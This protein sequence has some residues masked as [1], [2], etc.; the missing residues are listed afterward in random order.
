MCCTI[1]RQGIRRLWQVEETAEITDLCI[2]YMDDRPVILYVNY[3]RSALGLVSMDG[4]SLSVSVDSPGMKEPYHTASSRDGRRLVVAGWEDVDKGP[5]TWEVYSVLNDHI[6]KVKTFP[7]SDRPW[8]VCWT[9]GDDVIML[10]GKV[11][12][13]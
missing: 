3:D 9:G 7:L 2:I 13:L 12:Y 1:P 6:S 8:S 4:Q 5:Y 11:T 10:L